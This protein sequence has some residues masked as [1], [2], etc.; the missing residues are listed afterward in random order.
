MQIAL[1]SLFIQVTKLCNATDVIFTCAGYWVS[2]RRLSVSNHNNN[3]DYNLLCDDGCTPWELGLQWARQ[4]R[5][6]FTAS[7]PLVSGDPSRTG[8]GS[9]WDIVCYIH[10][11]ST[12]PP[13]LPPSPHTHT[14]PAVSNIHRPSTVVLLR[15]YTTSFMLGVDKFGVFLRHRKRLWLKMNFTLHQHCITLI[16]LN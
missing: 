3:G 13:S 5:T 14:P 4:V 9:V 11:H 2:T 12:L 1:R 15:Q 7:H 8:P 6:S 16:Y 10:L